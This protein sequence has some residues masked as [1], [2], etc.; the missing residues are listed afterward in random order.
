MSAHPTQS[1]F[2]LAAE[3]VSGPA[4]DLR[5]MRPGNSCF[6]CWADLGDPTDE[7]EFLGVEC[8]NDLA[9]PR[10]AEGFANSDWRG[11]DARRE[12]GTY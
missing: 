2:K 3:I 12:L 10:C 4:A 8:G 7:D 5:S 1:F 6:E 11:F 9:C